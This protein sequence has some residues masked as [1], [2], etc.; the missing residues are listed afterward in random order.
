MLQSAQI[1]AYMRRKNPLIFV[2]VFHYQL[3]FYFLIFESFLSL[4]S[5]YMLIQTHYISLLACIGPLSWS[6]TFYKFSTILCL[7]ILCTTRKYIL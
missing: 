6:I 5:F 7:E 3:I 2:F 1:F 4:L